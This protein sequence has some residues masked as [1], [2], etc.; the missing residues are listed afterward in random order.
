MTIARNDIALRIVIG[1]HAR[2]KPDAAL[3][4]KLR[5]SQQN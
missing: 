2:G 5:L 1:I 4:T 3:T